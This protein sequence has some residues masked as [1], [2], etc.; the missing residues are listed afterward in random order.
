MAYYELN[1]CINGNCTGCDRERH[2]DC[3]V[4][5][6][7]LKKYK[8]LAQCREFGLLYNH[9]SEAQLQDFENAI[10]DYM[11]NPTE[12]KFETAA[13][14]GYSDI[15]NWYEGTITTEN[16]FEFVETEREGL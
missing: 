12:E 14:Y 16:L 13:V 10:A 4:I 11:E 9:Y 3:S 5:I 7:G 8:Y 15:M 6:D 1:K 2:A